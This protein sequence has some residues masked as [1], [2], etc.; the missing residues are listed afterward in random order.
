MKIFVGIMALAGSL[1]ASPATAR[2]CTSVS[3][4]GI[5]TLVSIKAAEP[6][7]E[8]FY[9]TAPNEVMRFTATGSFMYL[10][11]NRPFSASEAGQR[12]DAADARD[13]TSYRYSMGAAGGMMILRQ[14][15][16]FQAFRC[17][18]ADRVEGGARPGDMVLS[19]APG[20][21]MLRRVQR[22]VK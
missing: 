12:L 14:G 4:V 15:T 20:A 13:G 11:S 18:I 7:V 5:W 8:E 10:A 2:P 6:G 1:L 19:N 17:E 21:A 3:A 16:P 9:K 22:K